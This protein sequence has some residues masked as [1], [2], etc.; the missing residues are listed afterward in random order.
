MQA[1]IAAVLLDPEARRGDDPAAENALD[2]HLREPVLLIA[3]VLRALNA[4]TDGQNLGGVAGYLGQSPFYAPSVFNFYA[5]TF[6]I[7]LTQPALFGPEF[8][9]FTTVNSLNRANV[10]E[11]LIF[12]TASVAAG[13]QIDLSSI[14]AL[15]DPNAMLDALNLRLLHGSMSGQMRASILTAVNAVDSGNALARAQ[16]AAYLILSSSQY[17]VQ[18]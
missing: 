6:R 4:K 1:L 14:A 7:P 17:Q 2:G 12:N 9:I 13:T 11:A 8:Q 5:P 10:V 15:G 16:T 3:N 18:R